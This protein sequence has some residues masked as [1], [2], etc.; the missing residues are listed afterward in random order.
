MIDFTQCNKTGYFLEIRYSEWCQER[1]QI[2]EVDP[3]RKGYIGEE[4]GKTF[5]KIREKKCMEQEMTENLSI[6]QLKPTVKAATA[7]DRGTETPCAV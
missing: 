5:W 4:E 1:S 3:I 6:P 7:Q 2:H